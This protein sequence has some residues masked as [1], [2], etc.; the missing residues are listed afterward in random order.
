MLIMNIFIKYKHKA[1]NKPNLSDNSIH[2]AKAHCNTKKQFQ[3]HDVRS[4]IPALKV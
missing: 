3:S 2:N 4:L 1:N